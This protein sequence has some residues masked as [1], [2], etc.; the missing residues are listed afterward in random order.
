MAASGLKQKLAS[1]EW[2]LRIALPH[3]IMLPACTLRFA[4]E[5]EAIN[6][7]VDFWPRHASIMA[8]VE[9]WHQSTLLRVEIVASKY[10]FPAGLASEDLLGNV[11]RAAEDIKQ[12]N[13]QKL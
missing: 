10:S 13:K 4:S 11:Q 12:T 6:T 2:K 3:E 1:N 5:A 9:L 7:P 8:G